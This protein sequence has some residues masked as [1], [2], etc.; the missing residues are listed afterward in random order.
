MFTFWAL[1]AYLAVLTILFRMRGGIGMFWSTAAALA[2]TLL[3]LAKG[4]DPPL[5]GSIVKLFGGMAVIAVLL[6]ITSSESG[7]SAFFA[8]IRAVMVERHR[9][10]LLGVLL[11]V[12]PGLVAWQSYVAALPSDVAPPLIRSVHPAPPGTIAVSTQGANE[13]VT[14]DIIKDD[15]PFRA[16]QTTN[17]PEF[18][19]RV[20]RGKV[21]YYQNCF[22]CHGD[23]LAADGHYAN[24]MRPPPA[25]FQD[26]SVLPLFTETFFFWRIAKGGPG[27]PAAATPWDSVMPVWESFLSPDD[28]WSVI[29]FLY[30]HTGFKPRGHEPAG[31]H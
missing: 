27:L 10:P 15:N 24:A 2:V 17:P 9:Q 20:A 30:D 16:L 25:D 26:A 11:L 23:H 6:Y 28:M 4:F 8:P 29:L 21:V 1:I 7:R 3:Y 22:Y 13:P 31:G 19:S 18:A 5:P 14:V 12:I